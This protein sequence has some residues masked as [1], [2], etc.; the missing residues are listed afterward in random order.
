MQQLA[1]A[2]RSGDW[3]TRHATLVD[4]LSGRLDPANLSESTP[5]KEG[6][7]DGMQGLANASRCG[8]ALQAWQ[9]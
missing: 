4:D 8:C 6:G 1:S 5:G 2:A 7:I 9:R 3:C